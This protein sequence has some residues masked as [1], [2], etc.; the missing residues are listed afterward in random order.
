[1]ENTFRTT[2]LEWLR[3]DPDLDEL[4][5]IEEE[6]P[7][8]SSP[9]WLGIAASQSADW[10]CKDRP[11]REIRIALELESKVDDPAVDT[12]LISAIEQRVLS[13]PRSQ[14][15]FEI[16]SARFLRGRSERRP[17]NLRGALLEFR[18]RILET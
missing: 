15:G 5:A 9:P 16:V 17:N 7:V 4:N 8:R 6:S 10:G 11:G 12:E 3:T 2:I 1:M 18:F 14:N 13:L